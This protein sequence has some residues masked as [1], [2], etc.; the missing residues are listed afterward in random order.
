MAG[1][2]GSSGPCAARA[3]ATESEIKS[4]GSGCV[5]PRAYVPRAA[6]GAN[7]NRGN[8]TPLP[9]IGIASPPLLLERHEALEAAKDHALAVE[10]HL[11]RP[12][13]AR[14]GHHLGHDL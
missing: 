10:R 3:S 14:V 5:V 13:E 4:G 6:A 8:A 12:L 9:S 11:V 2:R 1:M 7:I